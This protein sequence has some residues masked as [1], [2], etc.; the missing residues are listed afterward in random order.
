MPVGACRS[1]LK[2]AM[3]RDAAGVGNID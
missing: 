1:V 3:T 2:C